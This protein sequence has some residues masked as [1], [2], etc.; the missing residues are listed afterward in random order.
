[1]QFYLH[2]AYRRLLYCGWGCSV[3]TGVN[4]YFHGR[5]NTYSRPWIF[6]FTGMK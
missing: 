6:H 5:E 1:M 3:F 4:R 2:A